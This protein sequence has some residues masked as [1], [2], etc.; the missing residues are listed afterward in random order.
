MRVLTLLA[1]G[2]LVGMIVGWVIGDPRKARLRLFNKPKKTGLCVL[3]PPGPAPRLIPSD[4]PNATR[5]RGTRV[6][7][8]RQ[9]PAGATHIDYIA[10]FS[11]SGERSEGRE[12]DYLL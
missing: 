7:L 4:S 6:P 10:A 9:L 2:C 5:P 12:V 8:S 11:D 1:L 3:V